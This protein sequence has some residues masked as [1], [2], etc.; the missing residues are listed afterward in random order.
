MDDVDVVMTRH[1]LT[2]DDYHRMAEVGILGR[3]DRVELIDGELIAMAP[4]GQD[5]AAS[6]NGLTRVLVMACGDRAIVSVQN[7]V[8][9]NRFNEPQPDAALFRPRADNYRTGAPPG[10]ADVLLLVE[11]ADTTLRYDRAVKL[12]LYARAGIAEVWIVDLH[13]RAVDVHRTPVGDAYKTVETHGPGD[14]VTL[15]L[16]PEI[17]VALDPVFA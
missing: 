10:P 5:H 7:S 2:V 9:L 1:R 13:R 3:D 12:P 4:I 15:A 8:R 16:A 6:V 17:A 14:T 11:V